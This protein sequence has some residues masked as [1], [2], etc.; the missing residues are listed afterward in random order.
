MANFWELPDNP[1]TSRG[2][3]TAGAHKIG[4]IRRAMDF[5]GGRRPGKDAGEQ[6]GKRL[7]AQ[8][9]DM[10]DRMNAPKDMTLDE[11]L[12]RYGSG[13]SG[14]GGGGG[15][16][17]VN[18][19][20]ITDMYNQNDAALESLYSMAVANIEAQ[21]PGINENYDAGIAK[22]KASGQAATTNITGGYQAARDAQTAQL[23]ALGIGDVAGLLANQG[24]KAAADQ[25]RATG[26]VN[27]TQNQNVDL[28]TNNQASAINHNTAFSQATAQRGVESRDI[29]RQQM[30]AQIQAA[31]SGGGGGG[32][33]SRGGGGM[34]PSDMNA[35][36]R[37]FY[38]YINPQTSKS[39]QAYS[40]L[41]QKENQFGATF[42]LDAAK[43]G[44]QQRNNGLNQ[45]FK[46]AALPPASLDSAAKWLRDNR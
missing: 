43:F 23:A 41:L 2:G 38:D 37:T 46:A 14:G 3:G 20:P 26:N 30:Q 4:A 45:T 36:V 11:W 16:G 42:G 32:G 44:E 21:Q 12:A 7:T 39:A 27:Q 24:G 5:S 18:T 8:T 40:G 22:T 13:G 1:N 29:L 28:L 6:Q 19:Q 31:R 10:I 25:A 34:R 33:G 9:N 35:A 17:R 15:G